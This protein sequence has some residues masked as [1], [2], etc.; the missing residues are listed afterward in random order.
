VDEATGNPAQPEADAPRVI[1]ASFDDF[2]A[3]TES[4]GDF[5]SEYVQLDPGPVRMTLTRVA[6]DRIRLLRC[7]EVVPSYVF[8]AAA[9]AVPSFAFP[10]EPVHE[11]VWE[12]QPADA[13]TLIL[14]SPGSEVVGRS[15]GSIK[16]ATLLFEGSDLERQ[17]DR[18]GVALTPIRH[19]AQRLAPDPQA[20]AALRAATIEC[21]TLAMTVPPQVLDDPG[22]RRLQE[23]VLL[24]AAVHAASSANE[25]RVVSAD[26]HRRA[27]Q[28][29]LELLEARSD[30]PVYLSDLCE[31]A[32]VSERTLRSAFQ[33]IHGVSPV[34][35][36]HRHRMRQVRRALLAADPSAVRVASVAARF[37]FANLGRFAVEFRELFGVSPSQLL[38]GRR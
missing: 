20:M 31:A 32:G 17:A 22:V 14:Y 9:P 25:T 8:R 6:L 7:E 38:R 23:E 24:T 35:Y 33:R 37:G 3:V 21:F 18:L 10:L 5:D 11:T 29:A 34:R 16:W 1:Q 4:I 13:N 36:I 19:P 27:V 28:R 30:E 26:S 2:D 12:G 15:H